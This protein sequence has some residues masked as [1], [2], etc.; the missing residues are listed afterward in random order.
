MS[1][2]NERN[3]QKTYKCLFPLTPSERKVLAYANTVDS[4]RALSCLEDG[5]PGSNTQ[6]NPASTNTQEV[7][8]TVTSHHAAEPSTNPRVN[9]HFQSRSYKVDVN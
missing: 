7:T 1:T 3:H 9:R 6:R 4:F 2:E 5:P 8:I